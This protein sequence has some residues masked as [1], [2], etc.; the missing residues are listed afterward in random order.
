MFHT[1]GLVATVWVLKVLLSTP[2]LLCTGFP[3]HLDPDLILRD[4][5]E[6]SIFASPDQSFAAYCILYF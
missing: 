4:D 6:A 2:P 1:D 5:L 3:L